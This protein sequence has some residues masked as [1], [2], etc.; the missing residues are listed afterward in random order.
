MSYEHKDYASGYEQAV[1]IEP[2]SYAWN[3][4]IIYPEYEVRERE[5]RRFLYAPISEKQMTGRL[6]YR[7]LSRSASSLFLE[8]A[9]W[10][11]EYGMDRKCLESGKNVDAA[12]QWVR[13]FGVLGVDLPDITVWGES[14]E[15]IE[16]YLGRP[17]PDG[18]QDRGSRSEA[19]GGRSE[20]VERFAGEAW[21]ANM[22]LRL[23]E[24]ATNLDGVDT[25]T[26][27]GFM[28]DQKDEGINLRT[29]RELHGRT[30]EA[31]RS[32]A[33]SVVEEAVE[34]KI[35]GRCWPVPVRDGRSHNQGWAFDSLLGAMWLQML[36]LMLGQSRRCEWCG[37]LLAVAPEQDLNTIAKNVGVGGRRKPRNDRRFC[38]NRCKAKWN[39][40]R[41]TGA[42]SKRTRKKKREQPSK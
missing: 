37:K 28:S 23:Y 9:R 24:A 40:H 5:G 17:G 4:W 33:L 31:A 38:G 21:E 36:W 15:A 3:E 41:G 27:V 19:N 26:I 14:S 35:R 13:T 22:V 6:R 34:R 11:E 10:P 25:A 39:Y 20:T 18:F 1:D 8:F 12:L 2:E 29:I 42:S 16:H 32:W 30:A 7:P